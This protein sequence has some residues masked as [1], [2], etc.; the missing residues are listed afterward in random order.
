MV[1]EAVALLK[2]LEGC[3]LD[4]YPDPESGGPPITIGYGATGPDIALG[5]TWTQ[6]Q[7]DSD[8]AVRVSILAGQVLGLIRAPVPDA[9]LPALISFCYNVGI[10]GF[11]EST[12]L[13]LINVGHPVPA[14]DEFLKWTHAAGHVSANLVRRRAIERASFLASLA[15]AS[16]LA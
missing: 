16:S 14:A 10:H 6:E 11:S 9:C 1:D 4:A 3:R 2:R 7:A 8:L 5:M 13:R 12:M 15:P